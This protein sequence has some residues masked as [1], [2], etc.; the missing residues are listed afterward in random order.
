MI[1]TAPLLSE[2]ATPPHPSTRATPRS[3]TSW[4]GAT[5]SRSA[6]TRSSR[7]RRRRRRRTRTR[8]LR[9]ATARHPKP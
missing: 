7:L 8:G 6:P 9:T 5:R 4:N 1:L 2:P 3:P